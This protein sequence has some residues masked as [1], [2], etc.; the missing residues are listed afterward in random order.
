M[1]LYGPDCGVLT[2]QAFH[3]HF[4]HM[5]LRKYPSWPCVLRDAPHQHVLEKLNA[6][7]CMHR[8]DCAK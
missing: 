3:L 1:R 4:R 8:S 2:L 6:S 5:L 7:A